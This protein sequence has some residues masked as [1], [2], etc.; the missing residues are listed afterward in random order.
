VVAIGHVAQRD[1]VKVEAELVLVEAADR[2]AGRPF[3]VAKGVGRLNV[4]AGQLFDRADRAGARQQQAD[5][6]LLNFLNLLGFTFAKDDNLGI[7]GFGFSRCG[8]FGGFGFNV[9]GECGGRQKLEASRTAIRFRMVPS[10]SFVR[11]GW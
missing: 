7:P 2:D 1:A 11:G 5:I 10:L 6:A 4:D 8:G 3:V 9:G